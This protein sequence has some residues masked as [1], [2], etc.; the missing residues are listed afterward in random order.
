MTNPETENSSLQPARDVWTIQKILV[1]ST[2]YLEKEKFPSPRLDAELLL[3]ETLK[4]KRIDL[5]INFDR[6]LDKSER[7]TMKGFLRRRI[8]GEPI[9]YILGRREFWGRE[10]AVSP[11]VLIPRPETEHLIEQVI[12][13]YKN[14]SQNDGRFLEIGV[15]SGCIAVTL[16]LELPQVAIDGW[17]ISPEALAVAQSNANCL[18][19][20]VNLKLCDALNKINWANLPRYDAIISNPPYIG[21]NERNT[22]SRSVVDFEPA[23]ALFASE[24]GVQFYKFI[25]EMAPMVLKSSGRLYLEIGA[26]QAS[27]V[28]DIL[29]DQGWSQIEIMKDLAGHDRLVVAHNFHPIS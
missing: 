22:L 15:G 2:Q 26:S 11:A 8:S 25:A 21:V 5:Y 9:A 6:P 10:F 14:F 28:R 27:L 19:A 24:D 3:C 20:K 23:I 12:K 7:E 18:H 29:A 4:C 13:D 17:D 16:A 1:W